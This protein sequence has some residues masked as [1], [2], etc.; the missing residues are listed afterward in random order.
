[1]DESQEQR[2]DAALQAIRDLFRDTDELYDADK[3][4]AGHILQAISA[5]QWAMGAVV[6][7]TFHAQMAVLQKD[8]PAAMLE[9]LKALKGVIDR[10]ELWAA[11]MS[12]AMKAGANSAL[13]S[14]I[15]L[16][17]Q[18]RDAGDRAA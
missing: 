11:P 5:G 10:G 4:Q 18:L 1:M 16:W 9:S 14:F 2:I 17:T 8:D 6:V 12:D 15:G 3:E 13:D 7:N